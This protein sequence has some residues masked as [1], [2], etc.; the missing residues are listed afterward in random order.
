MEEQEERLGE[1]EVVDDCEEAML[2]RHREK[3]STQQ[4]TAIVTTYTRPAQT[5]AK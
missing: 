5:Q 4:L 1:P 3:S 2:S